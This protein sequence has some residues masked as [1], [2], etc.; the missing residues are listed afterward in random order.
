MQP[1][2]RPK[3]C[4]WLL[5]GSF[6]LAFGLYNV[7]SL[8]CVSEG[9]ILGLALLLEHWFSIS[10]A[11]SGFIL[12]GL[13]YLFGW[14]I[15]GKS[16]MCYSLLATCGFSAAYWI[17]EQYP[18]LWPALAGMPLVASL[19]GALFVGVGVGICVRSGGA[20]TGDDALAMGICHVTGLQVQHVY[21][22]TDLSVILL[23]LTYIPLQRIGYSLLTV[24]LSGQLIGLIQRI[25]W[26]GNAR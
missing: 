18:P 11:V 1:L 26:E 24:V 14:K 23:S 22:I 7:H 6:I 9:G 15:L 13:C 17:C 4:I 3:N 2:I 20:P 5:F 12:N 10:P 8:S 16:F 21:F 19:L 25:K